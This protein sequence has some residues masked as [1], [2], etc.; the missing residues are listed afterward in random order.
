MPKMRLQ[1]PWAYPMPFDPALLLA[2]FSIDLHSLAE[3][4]RE[5]IV[6]HRRAD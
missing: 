2:G 4:G 1:A 3:H 5:H 6:E